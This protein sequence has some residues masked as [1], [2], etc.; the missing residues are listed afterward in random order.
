M[1]SNLPIGFRFSVINRAMRRQIDETMKQE[2]L[3][4]VQLF[5][6]CEL[7]R[8]EQKGMEVNQ[9]DL[10]NACHVTHPTMTEIIKRLEKKE[11]IVCKQSS[12]DRR[13]KCISS[14]ERANGLKQHLDEADR[15]AFAALCQGLSEQELEIFLRASEVIT[16]NAM[17]I[18]GKGCEAGLDKNTCKESEGI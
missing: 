2:E 4:G 12:I 15:Y 3:T 5:A 8:M 11:Y 6:L 14:L 1:D 9:R 16:Q 13:H 10:E 17:N 7:R 18:L